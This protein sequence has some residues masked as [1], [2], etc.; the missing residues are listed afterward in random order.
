[1]NCCSLTTSTSSLRM[2][3]VRS[4]RMHSCGTVS[5]A[6]GISLRGAISRSA[7][8]RVLCG[9]T[10]PVHIPGNETKKA[11]ASCPRL[12]QRSS[13]YTNIEGQ[14][15]VHYPKTTMLCQRLSL[16]SLISLLTKPSNGFRGLASHSHRRND[17]LGWRIVTTQI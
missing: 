8:Q 14:T 7:T 1:M 12:M 5:E 13:D 6:K 9:A 2:S 11:F 15:K 3:L 10:T 4:V 16:I 17:K